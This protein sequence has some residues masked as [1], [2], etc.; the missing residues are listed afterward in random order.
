MGCTGVLTGESQVDQEGES[1]ADRP[2]GAPGGLGSGIG[3]DWVAKPFKKSTPVSPTRRLTQSQYQASVTLAFGIDVTFPELPADESV[4]LEHHPEASPL[5]D[6]ET[7][8]GAATELGEQIAAQLVDRCDFA[9]SA[10]GCT[11]SEILPALRTLYR[12][13]V[14][15]AESSVISEAI[16][17]AITRS[18]DTAHG[19]SIGIARALIEPSFLYRMEVGDAQVGDDGGIGLSPFETLSRL[20]FLSSDEPP[21]GALL[22]LASSGALSDEAAFANQV[23]LAFAE[24]STTRHR[25]GVREED[26]GPG[27]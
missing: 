24:R 3:E 22:D 1:P 8:V 10:G 2:S 19:V 15:E 17:E 4:T 18:G 6:Y 16:S 9:T 13:D 12:T 23:E 21:S 25:L 14:G 20:S 27:K 26:A 7:Y 5:G 11:Q